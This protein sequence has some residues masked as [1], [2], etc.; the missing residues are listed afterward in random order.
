MDNGHSSLREF[1]RCRLDLKKKLLWA[2]DRPVQLPLKAVELLC[3]LVEGRGEVLTKEEIWRSVWNDSFVEET[4]LPHNIYLLRKVLKDLD[5]SG[6]IETVPRRGYRFA[7][8]VHEIPE[9]EIILHRHE[10]TRTTIEFLEAREN[11]AVGT[12]KTITLRSFFNSVSNVRR[13]L[14]IALFGLVLLLAGI[15]IWRYGAPTS[16]SASIHSIAVL[17]F[18]NISASANDHHGLGLADTLITRLG[19]IK[20]LRV[21]PTSAI[22]TFENSDIDSLQLGRKL[23]VDAILEGSI[24]RT[25]RA[26]RVTMR[27]VSIGDGNTIWSGDF[28][29][30]GVDTVGVDNEICLRAVDALSL[31][32][33]AA[34]RDLLTRRFTA[35]AEAYELYRNGRFEWNKRTWQGMINAE[36]FFRNAIEKD[37]D[38][39]LAYAGLA[40]G[41]ATTADPGLAIMN[42]QKAISLDPKLGEPH[43]TLGFIRMFHEWNWNEAESEFKQAIELSPGYATAHHWYAI[44]LEIKGRKAEAEV[45]FRRALDINPLSY[46]VLADLG[47]YNYFEHQYEKAAEYCDRALTLY[48][49]FSFAHSHLFDIDVQ[50]GKYDE[51]IEHKL[52]AEK[53]NLSFDTLTDEMKGKRDEALRKELEKYRSLGFQNFLADRSARTD[54][55]NPRSFWEA[56]RIKTHLGDKQAALDDLENCYRLR[57]TF[58]MPFVNVDPIFEPLKTEPRFRGLIKKMNL[59]DT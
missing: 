11:E 58:V 5:L 16:G 13:G 53:I 49:D 46:N 56:G 33:S 59:S 29:K 20:S 36:Q 55:K 54:P 19:R 50:L 25:D 8:E 3:V 18:R 40:D 14:L 9:E 51:A 24:Y 52:L 57:G 48:P 23:Q 47:E 4:N 37:P 22:A 30:R 1:G 12:T 41:L 27:L 17:P 44:L 15:G 28:E 32:L 38:F 7:G 35:D 42:A 10:L 6:L 34:E 26:V 39:A 43:A 45:E 2:N 31:D 21:R